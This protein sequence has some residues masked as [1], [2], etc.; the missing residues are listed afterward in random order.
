MNSPH[1]VNLGKR[2]GCRLSWRCGRGQDQTTAAAA[3]RFGSLRRTTPISTRYG[4]DRGTPVDRYY[5][6][7]FLAKHRADIRGA[8]L[9]VADARYTERFGTEVDSADV[10]DIEA[11]NPHATIVADLADTA[12]LPAERFDCFVLAQTL[13]YLFDVRAAIAGAHRMLRPGGVLLLTVPSV[14]KIDHSIGIEGDFWR[15]T[16][17]SCSRLLGDTFGSEHVEIRSYG[18]V[19]TAVAFLMGLACEELSP[20][21]LDYEDEL[22]PV[23]VAGRAVRC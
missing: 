1:T 12:A 4:F 5:I 11:G 3:R 21:E 14:T 19:L 18:N 2:A 22:F 10:L 13:Q 9:E 6:D 15:F 16:T 7:R 20:R 23:V 8:C 17:A